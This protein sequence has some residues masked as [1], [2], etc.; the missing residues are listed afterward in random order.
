[1]TPAAG[2]RAVFHD[3][4]DFVGH[5]VAVG[6]ASLVDRAGLREPQPPVEKVHAVHGALAGDELGVG[7]VNAVAVLVLQRDDGPGARL[8]DVERPVI[9]EFQEPRLAPEILGGHRNLIPRPNFE[10]R[11]GGLALGRSAGRRRNQP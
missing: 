2:Q 8:A 1:M 9:A 4:D 3:R 7:L 5:A 6:V 11:H 10:R